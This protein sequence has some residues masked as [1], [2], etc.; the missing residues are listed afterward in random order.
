MIRDARHTRPGRWERPLLLV[1]LGVSAACASRPPRPAPGTTAAGRACPQ[2]LR[3]MLPAHST[4][5]LWLRPR[6]LF[7]HAQLGPLLSQLTRDVGER[8]LVA[9]AERGG[10]DAR[11]VERSLLVW[12][13]EASLAI[14]A[15][16]FDARRVIDLHWERMLPPRR[17]AAASRGV[18]RIE[19]SLGGRAVAVAT[20]AACGLVAR[21]E[22]ETRLADRLL[23]DRRT[24]EG[25]PDPPEMIR[26]HFAGAPVEADAPGAAALTTTMRWCELRADPDA[27]GLRVTLV[28]AGPLPSDTPARVTR[29]LREFATS[30]IGD[31]VGA[32]DWL[33]ADDARWEHEGEEW[34]GTLGVPWRGLRALTTLARGAIVAPGRHDF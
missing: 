2:R 26:W 19:G 14:A 16:A 9:D 28:L 15:G 10:V 6:A 25:E 18:E 4:Q 32:D 13:G 7:D 5:W 17:R 23:D 24:R 8:A 31:A 3:A 22:R 12:R 11:T 20:D 34:R 27:D 21:A 33:R 1:A 29:L 30:P